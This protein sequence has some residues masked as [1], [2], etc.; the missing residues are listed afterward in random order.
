MATL[1]QVLLRVLGWLRLVAAVNRAEFELVAIIVLLLYLL[2]KLIELGIEGALI[3]DIER[4]AF[5][6]G[7]SD[8]FLQFLNVFTSGFF[9]EDAFET[10][11]NHVFAVGEAHSVR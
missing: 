1:I 2:E 11:F 10:S 4:N 3:I 9:N 8:E 6:L 7:D 5:L